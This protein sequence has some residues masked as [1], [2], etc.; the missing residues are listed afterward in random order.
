[1]K[2]A[3]LF[4][5]L[6]FLVLSVNAKNLTGPTP[7]GPWNSSFVQNVQ[8]QKTITWIS[9]PTNSE[10]HSKVLNQAL[11]ER[12]AVWV[13]E[14]PN[15]VPEYGTEYEIKVSV[16]D[17]NNLNQIYTETKE[18]FL[19]K[20]RSSNIDGVCG[21]MLETEIIGGDSTALINS[22]DF[23]VIGFNR[24]INPKDPTL[25]YEEVTNDNR[26]EFDNIWSQRISDYKN[27]TFS[28]K[29]KS[30]DYGGHAE[31][32][33]IPDRITDKVYYTNSL[34]IS[35]LQNVVYGQQTL[36]N[37]INY[38]SKITFPNKKAYCPWDFDQDFMADSWEIAEFNSVAN[39]NKVGNETNYQKL[40]N[41]DYLTDNE[42]SLSRKNKILQLR[43]ID[44]TLNFIQEETKDNI[45]AVNEYRGVI[46]KDNTY[47]RLSPYK[48]EFFFSIDRPYDKFWNE[49][50]A[51]INLHDDSLN[52][53]SLDS[54][55]INLIADS[56][57]IIS[58]IK[59]ITD[60]DNVYEVSDNNEDC[61]IIYNK[62]QLN[63]CIKV[64]IYFQS[65]N[66]EWGDQSASA[67]CENTFINRINNNNT[68]Y[69][70]Y[71]SNKIIFQIPRF[72]YDFLIVFNNNLSWRQLF[73]ITLKHELGHAL[74]QTDETTVM[75]I[76]EYN[77]KLGD[78]FKHY[79]LT[80]LNG[81]AIY[82]QGDDI[83]PHCLMNQ[84]L[85]TI[86]LDQLNYCP[87]CYIKLNNNIRITEVTE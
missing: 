14:I 5:V 18:S 37:N 3:L 68:I 58:D 17:P 66:I 11:P 45:K 12:S 29:L 56:N 51:S 36:T 76:D 20:V 19:V 30:Y 85:W 71:Y 33:V 70:L 49:C 59:S 16:R 7:T 82:S 40:L 78:F 77:F 34:D 41:L 72:I 35:F 25:N 21:N 81:C 50:I 64:R 32:E 73:M 43:A 9:N 46:L 22:K 1:M 23:Q 63:E 38:I 39:Y 74:G 24:E 26:N 28:L 44:S 53:T 10:T 27:G 42:I 47:K 80:D 15:T 83:I 87:K 55:I 69:D 48:Q 75:L 61:V 8:F 6:V 4:L 84:N 57:T 62:F 13:V 54:N 86:A 2:K 79:F 60:Y 31:I 52:L 67:Y 65:N